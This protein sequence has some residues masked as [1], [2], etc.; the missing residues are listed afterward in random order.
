MTSAR[1]QVGLRS[2]P[3][4]DGLAARPLVGERPRLLLTGRT[5][6]SVRCS[7]HMSSAF[8]GLLGVSDR[9]TDLDDW[10]RSTLERLCS[11]R[12]GPAPFPDE[13]LPG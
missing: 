13:V 9:M 6:S 11:K 8:G 1:P 3:A 10:G 7:P 12:P 5:S 4:E 2:S